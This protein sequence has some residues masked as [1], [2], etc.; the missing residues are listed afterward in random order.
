MMVKVYMFEEQLSQKMSI[1]V[2]DVPPNIFNILLA[3]LSH[4]PLKIYSRRL[5]FIRLIINEKD[6]KI[7]YGVITKLND[8]K[9]LRVNIDRCID[10]Q[11]ICMKARVMIYLDTLCLNDHLIHD[12]HFDILY[13]PFHD[14]KETKRY[15]LTKL[16]YLFEKKLKEYPQYYAAYHRVGNAPQNYEPMIKAIFKKVVADSGEEANFTII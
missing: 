14:A 11:L 6:L 15:I 10:E 5:K 7:L 1:L 8:Y 2:K 13:E 4:E 16:Y 9:T 3:T 12:E